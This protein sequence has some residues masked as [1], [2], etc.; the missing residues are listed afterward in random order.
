MR[1]CEEHALRRP[2]RHCEVET[3]R[4]AGEEVES[5]T[6]EVARLRRL[7]QQGVQ[8]AQVTLADSEKADHLHPID[9]W[10]EQTA[11]R[12]FLAAAAAEIGDSDD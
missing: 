9:A 7:L 3:L 1:I 8:I 10:L 2:C 11:L 4:Q 6:A 5:L 12:A